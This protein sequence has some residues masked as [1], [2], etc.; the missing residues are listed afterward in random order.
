MKMGKKSLLSILCISLL[1]IMMISCG[2]KEKVT[3]EETITIFYN[4]AFKGDSTG[5]EKVKITKAQVDETFASQKKIVVDSV[6]ANF[7]SGGITISDEDIDKMY[8][9]RSE[10]FK[11]VTLTVETINKDDKSAKVKIGTTYIK[12]SELD[13]KAVNDAIE[14]VTA[15]MLT[16]EKA[17]TDRLTA[18]Y[19]ENIV[20][21]YNNVE[22][23]TDNKYL[24]WNFTFENGV[25]QPENST[26][27]GFELGKLVTGQ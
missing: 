3:I 20:N 12:E 11:K 17:I 23:S 27:F 9:S 2:K 18:L 25:W 26:E 10:A 5:Y 22:T 13:E 16:D 1:G 19:I 4:L 24:E 14:T 8:T 15:Q 7:A 21:A 6:K